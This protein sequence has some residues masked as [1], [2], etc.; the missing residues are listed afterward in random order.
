[1]RLRILGP[2]PHFVRIFLGI[3]FHGG[4]CSTIRIA[5]SQYRVYRAAFH[6]V[7]FRLDGL[8]FIGLGIFGVIGNRVPLGLQFG[9]RAFDLRNRCA[10]IREFDDVGVRRFHHFAEEG[11]VI[12]LPLFRLQAVGKLRDN[13]AG[14]RN[15]L[16]ADVHT[17]GAGK[18]LDDRQ[19]RSARQFRS[20]VD[21]GIDNIR[22][23]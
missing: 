2:Y 5:L 9:H 14:Q 3:L 11:E 7:E 22:F 18:G 16:P 23:C 15:I 20:L 10:D 12:G 19:K 21:F 17:R 8:F 4:R 13:A 6:L 1:M